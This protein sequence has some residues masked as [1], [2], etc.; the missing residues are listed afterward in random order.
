MML[1]ELNQITLVAIGS[2][3]IS[4]LFR[5]ILEDILLIKLDNKTITIKRIIIKSLFSAFFFGIILGT[6]FF[7]FELWET[8]VNIFETIKI[9]I[10]LAIWLAINPL[11]DRLISFLF[12]V[13]KTSQS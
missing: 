2:G 11:F 1:T 9:T 3:L 10:I 7:A 12:S 8:N 4:G 5:S 6:I 13:F